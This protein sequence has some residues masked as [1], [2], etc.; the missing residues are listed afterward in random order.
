M[1]N[2]Y[3]LDILKE[4]QNRIQKKKTPE[5]LV[6]YLIDTYECA[7]VDEDTRGIAEQ[8][9]LY[10]GNIDY[11]RKVRGL[12][13]TGYCSKILEVKNP[14]YYEDFTDYPEFMGRVL[15]AVDMLTGY[16]NSNAHMLGLEMIL[17]KGL[18]DED[19]WHDR[20]T[21]AITLIAYDS[22]KSGT[23]TLHLF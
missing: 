20:I 18:A 7:E 16:V 11:Y 4:N 22:Y 15:L 19:T 21:Y 1:N 10:K 12:K 23:D 6:Q 13:Q 2:R 3:F 14:V 5:E 8:I 17:A 9:L